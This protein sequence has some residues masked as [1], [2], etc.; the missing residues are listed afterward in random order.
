MRED[1]VRPRCASLSLSNAG[2]V[3]NSGKPLWS[4]GM[5]DPEPAAPGRMRLQGGVWFA[6]KSDTSV[7]GVIELMGRAMEPDTPRNLFVVERLGSR[8]GHALE[9]WR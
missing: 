8:L 9:A 2:H 6:V 7:Y 1:E 4:S 5:L 3:W